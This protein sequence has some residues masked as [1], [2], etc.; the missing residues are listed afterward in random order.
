MSRM[1]TSLNIIE[2][3]ATPSVARSRIPRI[4]PQNPIF[5]EFFSGSGLVSHAIKSYFSLAWAN[6]ICSKKASIFCANHDKGKFKLD[7]ITAINGRNLPLAPLSWASFPCQDLSLA[8]KTGGIRASRSGLVWEWLRVMDE[9]PQRP[10][11]LVAENVVGLVSWQNGAHYQELHNAMVERGYKVGA[12]ML[13]AIRWLPHS[14]PRVFVVAVHKSV[15]I[16]GHLVDSSS[17]WLHSQAVVKAAKGLDSWLWWKMPE[18]A[19]RQLRLSDI[20]D[21]DAPCFD[22]E[23]NQ[24][25]ISLIPAG[26]LKKLLESDL[27]AVPGYKRMRHGQQVLELRFDDVAGCLRTPQGGSSRQFLVIKHGQE[28]QSRLLTVS[29][30]AKLMGAPDTYQLPGGYNDGYKAMGD[31]VAVPVAT[32]LAKN[33]LSKLAAAL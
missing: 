29:E 17:N 33:L 23:A 18:P 28:L 19:P 30:T 13:D 7:S 12:M 21:W 2:Y 26:H 32:Y 11:I 6:D 1:A 15:S 25:T 8:G 4:L 24:R 10:P 5:L 27:K 14:R 16:P 22:S 9:M 31:A 3:P 20:I